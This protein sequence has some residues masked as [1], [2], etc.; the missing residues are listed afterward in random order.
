ML[1]FVI[2]QFKL[3]DLPPASQFPADRTTA[4]APTGGTWAAA[5]E[6]EK[7]VLLGLR[8]HSGEATLHMFSQP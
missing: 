3:D 6:S 4:T 5:A 1:R 7:R 2:D 8:P